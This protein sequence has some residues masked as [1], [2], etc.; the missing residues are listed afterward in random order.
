MLVTNHNTNENQ[1]TLPQALS[2]KICEAKAKDKVC[3]WIL[4]MLP[5]DP[6]KKKYTTILLLTKLMFMCKKLVE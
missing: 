1:D 5:S 4:P 3:T 2:C 6:Q